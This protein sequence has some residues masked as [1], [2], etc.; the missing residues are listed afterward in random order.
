MVFLSFTREFIM[1]G[2]LKPLAIRNGLKRKAKQ[3]S[4]MEQM[5]T[6]IYFAVVGP[7]GLYVMS[8]TPVWCFNT[9]GMYEGFP[10]MTLQAEFKFCYLFQRAYWVQQFIVMALGL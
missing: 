4:F 2:L 5:Y 3:A 1:Q 7:A 9:L 6:A 8:R 10:H